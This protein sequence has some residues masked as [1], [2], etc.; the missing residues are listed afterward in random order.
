[1]CWNNFACYRIAVARAGLTTPPLRPVRVDYGFTPLGRRLYDLLI[2]LEDW[3]DE[4]IGQVNE[5]R[6]RYDAEAVDR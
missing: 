4:N 3:A 6:A 2:M 5:A 1:M